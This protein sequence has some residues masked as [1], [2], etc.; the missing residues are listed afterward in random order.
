MKKIQALIR[1]KP[2]LYSIARIVLGGYGFLKRGA[3]VFLVLAIKKKNAIFDSYFCKAAKF[4]SVDGSYALCDFNSEK[5]IVSS[6]DLVIGRSLYIKGEFDFDKFV[7]VFSL[8]DFDSTKSSMTLIDI[9]ANIGS[10][11]IPA[12][13]R[14]YVDKCIAFEP[15]PLNL[16]LL[17]INVILNGL[18]ENFVVYPVALGDKAGEVRFEL[19]DTNYGDHRVRMGEVEEG[20]YDEKNRKTISVPMKTLDEYYDDFL[21]GDFLIWMDTQGF[22]GYVLNG[23]EK[24]TSLKIPIVLEFWPYGLRR[25]GCFEMLLEF[26]DKSSYT[27]FIDLD[28]SGSEKVLLS[29]ENLSVLAD[30]LSLS[31]FDRFTD[32]LIL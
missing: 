28:C 29:K 27:S 7:Q 18:E 19:S 12:V 31:E 4:E 26:L 25:S 16:K 9:G 6:R 2:F 32:I 11:G 17:K 15:E 23:A 21:H 13:S 14:G 24:T 8:L 10:I 30:E 5:Y 3:Y 1:S 20:L 22:E